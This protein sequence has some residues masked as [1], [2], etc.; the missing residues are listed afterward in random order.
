MHYFHD[1]KTKQKYRAMGLREENCK[2]RT[3]EVE[4]ERE[5]ERRQKKRSKVENVINAL[6]SFSSTQ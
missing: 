2:E 3:M 1:G 6:L 5:R 4:R